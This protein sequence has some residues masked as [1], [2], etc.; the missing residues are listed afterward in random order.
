MTVTN[1]PLAT[2]IDA[3][4]VPL[5]ALHS[6]G[7]LDEAAAILAAHPEVAAA[8][9]HAAAILGDDVGVRRFLARDPAA[10]TAKGGPRGW[11]ALTHLCFS[12]YLRLDAN[13]SAGFVRAAEALLDAGAN[14]NTGWHE[15]GHQPEPIWESAIYGAA[16]IVHHPELT[17]LLLDRGA[18]P[19]DGETPYHAPES[20]DNR[21]LAVLVESG[22]LTPASLATMLVR[23]VDWHDHDGVAYLLAHGADP[24]RLRPWRWTALQHAL[25]RDNR[26]ETIALMLDHGADPTIPRA[27]DGRTAISIAAR[28]GRGDVLALLEERGVALDLHGVERLIAACARG[29]ANAVQSIAASEP[30]LVRQ[31]VAEGG[32]LLAELA[33]NG[34]TDGVRLLLDLSVPVTAR[35]ESGDGYFGIARGSTALHVAA[36]RAR[37]QTVALLIA[38]GAPVDVRDAQGQ[39]PLAL[40]VK[41]CVDSYWTFRRSPDSVRALLD[42]GASARDV[43][44]PSGYAE[45]DALLEAHRR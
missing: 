2:F 36:W 38:R 14:P 40:A 21:A 41:A 37:H 28:R 20:S 43:A 33:G 16:G 3:A 13:R 23:K 31:L 12:R 6:S 27:S 45:V 11:D 17:R 10:A 32:T 7:T 8:S 35:Y 9:I 4:C 5:D 39:T 42:A 22:K 25:Q 15:T 26:L 18:D 24:N 1:D 34:N 44:F 29:D 19:N 30:A